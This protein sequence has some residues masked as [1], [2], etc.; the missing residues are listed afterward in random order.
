MKYRGAGMVL[1]A[2]EV[3]VCNRLGRVCKMMGSYD[4][5]FL[6]LELD[7]GHVIMN[8]LR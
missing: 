4:R 2:T 5:G 3:S 6:C 8:L 7:L 1:R